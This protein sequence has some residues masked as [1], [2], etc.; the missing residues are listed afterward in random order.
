MRTNQKNRFN[1]VEECWVP[2]AGGKPA[3]LM[4]LFTKKSLASFG[5]NPIEKIALTKLALAVAQ[6]AC[7]PDDEN[8]WGKLGANGLARAAN[9]Y[10][11]ENKDLFWLYGKRPFL[12]MPSVDTAEKQPYGALLPMVATGNT[13]VLIQ[14]Q[15]PREL[16]D[17][18][19]ALLL[20]TLMSFAAGGKKVD[21]SLV[22]SKDYTGKSK[23]AKP[24][25]S[26]GYLG[27]LHSFVKGENL[28][29]TIWLNIL[30]KRDIKALPME[31]GLGIPPWERMPTGENDRGA[32]LIRKSYLGRL[33]PLSRFVLLSDDGV[34]YSEGVDFANH[35]SGQWDPSITVDNSSKPKAIWVDPEKR[36]WRQLTALLS[37]LETQ[38]ERSYE[39]LQVRYAVQRLAKPSKKSRRFYIWSGGLRVSFK[40][41][42]QFATGLDDF[43]ESEIS[44]GSG[45]LSEPW[46]LALKHEMIELDSLS[47]YLFK[48]IAGYYSQFSSDGQKQAVKAAN[49]FWVLC[50][51]HCQELVDSCDSP[52]S[53]SRQK[54]RRQFFAYAVNT[55]NRFCPRD[56]SRQIEAWAKNRLKANTYLGSSSREAKGGRKLTG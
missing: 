26:L 5:G 40:A 2:I 33:V 42:E 11:E 29:D 17:P 15:I 7:T 31:G 13:T 4:D 48:S 47:R 32:N 36:P 28:I 21:N 1:L 37:F 10:L 35:K 56:S 52:D 46:F 22:L 41:G 49:A 25:P 18:E 20:V 50:E 12:Q 34:H 16:S 19:K 9:K 14:S 3:S 23:A 51:P 44:I 24:G 54:M 43:V 53:D 38:A 30:T 6:A 55:Y 27:Y 8:E 39:C 45:Q